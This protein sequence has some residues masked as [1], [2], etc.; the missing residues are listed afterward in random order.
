MKN[1]I[2]FIIWLINGLWPL[3]VILICH[4][5]ASYFLTYKLISLIAQ[6]LGGVL[7]LYSID[8]NIQTFN[9]K[10]IVAIFKDWLRTNPRNKRSVIV[11]PQ[12]GSITLTGCRPKLIVG[13]NPRSIDEKFE[14][15]QEQI[16]ELTSEVEY[17]FK[18]LKIKADR[19]V[20]ETKGQINDIKSDLDGIELK[21]KEASIGGIKIQVFGVLLMVYGAFCGYIA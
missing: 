2:E 17:Q 15:L 8:S 19:H 1:T 16:N 20:K 3:L 4:P 9:E 14:F 12:I 13:R 6:I 10:N 18:E 21:I 5:I 7:V 11:Q